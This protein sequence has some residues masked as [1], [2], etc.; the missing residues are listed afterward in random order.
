[1]KPTPVL[2]VIALMSIVA[3]TPTNT[4][5]PSTQVPQTTTPDTRSPVTASTESA[6]P[7]TTL[8]ST[9]TSAAPLPQTTAPPAPTIPPA[10]TEA[11]S[12]T[13]G[14]TAAPT[15]SQ[16]PPEQ[17]DADPTTTAE[18]PPPSPD[19]TDYDVLYIGHSFGRPFAENL[20]TLTDSV[21]VD[22]TQHTIFRGGL[23][24]TPE[25]MWNNPETNAAIKEALD[26]GIIDMVVMVCCSPE[27]LATGSTDSAMYDIADYAIAQNPATAFR[28]GMIWEDF[29]ANHVDTAAHRTRT[30]AAL[31]A[32]QALADDLGDHLGGADVA[33][34][35]HGAAVY[36]LRDMFERGELPGIDNL[37]GPR[38]T[39]VFTDNKGHA[40]TLAKEVGTLIWLDSLFGIA[41]M[42]TPPDMS[43]EFDIRTIAAN[44]LD[45]SSSLWFG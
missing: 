23:N 39:S 36:E 13:D 43:Y 15:T 6:D 26:T 24:G 28:I 20:A 32:W 29:P 31:P 33:P 14:T 19:N 17:A 42:N 45:K 37:I 35:Y 27:L 18:T 22:H 21:G 7:T 4:A 38:H 1:M 5:S 41:P 40:G 12:D 9:T 30:D 2:T 44:A 16:A 10:T 34:F 25:L 8:R 3:C 11:P